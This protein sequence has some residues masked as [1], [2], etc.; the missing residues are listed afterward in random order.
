MLG[1][2]EVNKISKSD[3]DIV[4]EDVGDFGRE[5]HDSEV[6]EE[7]SDALSEEV[8]GSGVRTVSKGNSGGVD[9]GGC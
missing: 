3:E 2:R 1:V 6:E 9:G 7:S 4:V 5:V 8:D